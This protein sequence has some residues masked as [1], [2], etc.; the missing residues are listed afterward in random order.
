MYLCKFEDGI[1]AKAE[2]FDDGTGWSGSFSSSDD[3]YF[4]NLKEVYGNNAKDCI[5]KLEKLYFEEKEKRK[6]GDKNV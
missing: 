3:D 2:Y 6:K 1:E 4:Y 5:E